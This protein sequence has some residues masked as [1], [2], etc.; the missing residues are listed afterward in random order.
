MSGTSF[1]YFKK[2]KKKTN[3]EKINSSAAKTF[4]LNTFVPFF[5]KF[6]VELPVN[7]ILYTK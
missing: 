4:I 3:W 7:G 2:K 6:P 5:C 1:V